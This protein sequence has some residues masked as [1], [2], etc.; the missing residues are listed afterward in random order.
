MLDVEGGILEIMKTKIG[1]EAAYA[2]AK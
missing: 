1:T 2:I